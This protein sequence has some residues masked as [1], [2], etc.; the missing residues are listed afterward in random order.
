VRWP[1]VSGCVVALGGTAAAAAPRTPIP[2]SCADGGQNQ[3]AHETGRRQ[4]SNLVESAWAAVKRD[5][6]QR[7][8]VEQSVR[9]ALGRRVTPAGAS[10]ALTC[11]DTGF[12]AGATEALA[13]IEAACTGKE[14]SP[15]GR[16]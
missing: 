9:D 15:G 5:C 6:R 2:A 7:A 3:R 10:E 12:R 1:L 11:R 8:R 16:R 13:D 4:G 14:F